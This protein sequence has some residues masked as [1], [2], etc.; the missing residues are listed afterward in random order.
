VSEGVYVRSLRFVSHVD[1]RSELDL[2]ACLLVVLL[3]LTQR[4]PSDPNFELM[5]P[6]ARNGQWVNVSDRFVQLCSCAAIVLLLW[7]HGVA[8]W[9]V[10]HVHAEMA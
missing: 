9:H 10:S 1:Y 4:D 6:I 5:T 2:S 7:P 8:R 3:L